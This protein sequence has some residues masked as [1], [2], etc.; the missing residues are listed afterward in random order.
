MIVLMN[1]AIPL[2]V[3]ATLALAWKM[4]SK[5]VLLAGLAIAIIYTV[6]QPT[7]LP[8][9]TVSAPVILPTEFVDKPIVDRSLKPMT[10]AERDAKRNAALKEIN[11]NIENAIAKEKQ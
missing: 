6:T 5:A 4:K 11:D 8:K 7:M 3:L 2:I 10:D 1:Y 9:G